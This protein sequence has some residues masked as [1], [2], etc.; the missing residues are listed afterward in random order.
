MGS[1]ERLGVICIKVQWWWNVTTCL[2][3]F[4]FRKDSVHVVFRMAQMH[5]LPLIR[6]FENAVAHLFPMGEQAEAPLAL[7]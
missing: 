7:S 3:S 6:S 4:H 1:P 2:V 5:Q